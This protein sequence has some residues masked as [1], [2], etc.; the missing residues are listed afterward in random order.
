MQKSILDKLEHMAGRFEEIGALLVD[1]AIIG[2]QDRF[3][4][5]SKEYAQ[6]Q[7]LVQLHAAWRQAQDDRTVAADMQQ[8][9]DPALRSLGEEE[10]RAAGRKP[11]TIQQPV[12]LSAV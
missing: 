3:R 12:P 8:D 7:P 5:L 4:D 1:P 2:N 6:L 10:A 9:P 11:R